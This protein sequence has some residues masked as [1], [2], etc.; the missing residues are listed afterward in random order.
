MS[1]GDIYISDSSDDE[2]G[3]I[4]LYAEIV[5][6]VYL[7]YVESNPINGVT[8]EKRERWIEKLDGRLERAPRGDKEYRDQLEKV[9]ESAKNKEHMRYRKELNPNRV[10]LNSNTDFLHKLRKMIIGEDEDSRIMEKKTK[11]KL[12]D[13][14]K[15]ENDI[16]LNAVDTHIEIHFEEPESYSDDDM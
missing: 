10:M 1:S 2:S 14:A 4:D 16:L 13:L 9:L 15:N 5:A 11:K 8:D 3:R 6:L 7:L 12:R